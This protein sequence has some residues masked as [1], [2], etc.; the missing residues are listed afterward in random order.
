M[1]TN[2]ELTVRLM[3][4]AGTDVLILPMPPAFPLPEPS[5][6][7]LSL[8]GD[9]PH[10]FVTSGACGCG[11]IDGPREGPGR[12]LPVRFVSFFLSVFAV[13][14]VELLWWWGDDRDKLLTPPRRRMSWSDFVQRNARGQLESQIAYLIRG[15]PEPSS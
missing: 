6:A 10:Y 9:F 14:S 7:R 2:V 5:D 4:N 11:S 15:K 13:S 12:F 1:C 8:R 3:D